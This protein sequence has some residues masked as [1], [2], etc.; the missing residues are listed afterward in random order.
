MNLSRGGIYKLWERVDVGS[1]QLFQRAGLQYEADNRMVVAVLLKHLLGGGEGPCL[2]AFC[3]RVELQAA[4]EHFAHLHGRADI[5]AFA[6]KLEATLLHG[7]LA[8]R[9][10]RRKLPEL[11]NVDSHACPLHFGEHPRQGE[12]HIAKQLKLTVVGKQLFERLH[13][14]AADVG[15]LAEARREQFVGE[16]DRSLARSRRVGVISC[17]IVEYLHGY[18]GQTVAHLRLE[19]VVGQR[20]IEIWSNQVD[21]LAA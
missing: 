20:C 3:L 15:L 8:G 19:H 9:E 11:G 12:L 14:A 21:S 6:R 10:L 4:E 17:L 5:E 7:L 1:E 2:S 13:H 16:R 18:V